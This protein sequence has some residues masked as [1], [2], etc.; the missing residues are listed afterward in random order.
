V[1][2]NDHLY[3]HGQPETP[4]GGWKNSGIGFTHG[5]LGL[6]EMTRPKLL[7]WDLLYARRNLW[8][9]P[10][11]RKTYDR[12]RDGLRLVFPRNPKDIVIGGARVLVFLVRKMFTNWKAD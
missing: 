11:D 4:W 12:L 8:W 3:S 1:T 7:N 5:R 6:L 10:Y 9:F 2:I